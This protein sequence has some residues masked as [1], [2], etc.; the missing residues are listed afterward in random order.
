MTTDELVTVSQHRDSS[1]E[2][3][4]R[5]FLI[6]SIIWSSNNHSLMEYWTSCF[7]DFSEFT[8]AH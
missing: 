2:T 1:D 4:T 7:A 5:Q 6:T 3:A 8:Y